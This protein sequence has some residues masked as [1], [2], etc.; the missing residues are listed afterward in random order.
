MEICHISTR[1]CRCKVIFKIVVRYLVIF[2]LLAGQTTLCENLVSMAYDD[3][4]MED[5]VWMNHPV[6]HSVLFTPPCDNWTLCGI[7]VYG[8]RVQYPSS[9][10]FWIEILDENF[11]LISKS[12]GKISTFPEEE[13]QWTFVDVADV[14]VSREFFV[15]F[16]EFG[17]VYVGLDLSA[18]SDRSSIT[19]HES[20]GPIEWA[21][22]EYD[23]TWADWMIRAV[24]HSPNPLAYLNIPASIVSLDNPA[25]IGVNVS[26]PDGNLKSVTL[27]VVNN[28]S[29]DVVWSD[30]ETVGGFD[31]EVQF[32]WSGK[33]CEISN[34]QIS[35]APVFVNENVLGDYPYYLN[36]SAFCFLQL[37]PDG[38]K[39]PAFAYFGLDGSFNALIDDS[40]CNHYL[41]R[42]LLNIL[43]PDVDYMEYN[44]NNITLVR[45]KSCINFYKMKITSKSHELHL[46][47]L[48]PIVLSSS[49]LFNYR[50]KLKNSMAKPGDYR[51]MIEIEDHAYNVIKVSGF[52][53]IH[54]SY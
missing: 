43:C 45:D 16:Y 4:G 50:L 12:D 6:G 33:M 54:L 27:Y 44:K 34:G 1:D 42:D 13:F 26:D 10:T 24:G 25:I 2:L 48:P 7:E 37:V 36:R 40:R 17:G 14:N 51:L 30:L 21:F 35:I 22:P 5:A 19:S 47:S 32:T 29:G 39:I 15:N 9:D 3:D 53:D 49:P 20:H 38:K 8:K 18:G 41:S 11:N 31:E 23:Q 28:E 52:E 46:V